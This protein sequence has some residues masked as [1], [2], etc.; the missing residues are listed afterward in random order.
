M[1]A[2]APTITARITG[3]L[4]ISRRTIYLS[5][6]QPSGPG[7][8]RSRFGCST[9]L[10]YPRILE[11]VHAKSVLIDVMDVVTYP[12]AS[13]SQRMLSHGMSAVHSAWIS[14]QS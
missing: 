5:M 7:G 4:W 10:F 8:L 9:L 12:V 3:T 11:V 1:I 6:T 2:N 14:G 13:G